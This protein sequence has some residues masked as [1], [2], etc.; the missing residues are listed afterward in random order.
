MLA[1]APLRAGCYNRSMGDN[2]KA[3]N[4]T[5]TGRICLYHEAQ[6]AGVLDEMARQLAASLRLD[7]EIVLLGVL[8]R[9]VPLAAML[10]DRL[11]RLGV[12]SQG[13]FN[14]EVKRYADDLKVLYPATLLRD[15]AQ[16][17]AMDF[18]ETSVVVVDD[19]LYR[20]HS[21]LR[22][23]QHLVARGAAR[24]R[25]AVLVDRCCTVL[26]IRAD[27][28]GLRLQVAPDAIVEVHVPPYEEDLSVELVC[29]SP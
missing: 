7:E 18:S 12:R 10:D 28:A 25:S 17:S 26:P 6:L 13:R 9:G 15:D 8:R 23:V 20:G 14:L 19:V 27:V 1:F 2:E 22:V 29:P 24:V 3:D 21:L 5:M 16:E 4:I 11:R